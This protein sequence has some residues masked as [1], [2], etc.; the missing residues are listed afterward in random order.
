M[1]RKK[2]FD[3]MITIMISNEMHTNLMKISNEEKREMSDYIRTLIK[4]DFERRGIK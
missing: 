3:K 2:L 1:A 4:K